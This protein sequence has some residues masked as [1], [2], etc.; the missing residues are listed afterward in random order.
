MSKYAPFAE[1][2]GGLSADAARL[3]FAEIEQIIGASLPESAHRHAAWWANSRTDDSHVWAH[4]WLR[5]GWEKSALNLTERWVEFRRLRFYAIDSAE[6]IEGYE[7]DVKLLARSRNRELAERCRQRDNFS[8]QACHFRF[9]I[10]GRFV[11]DVHHKDPLSV[12]GETITNLDD[13]VCLCPTCHRIAHLRST[14]Y[15]VDEIGALR[16]NL[17]HGA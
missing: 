15:T 2:L 10:D 8:C 7:R 16:G 6:A 9:S 17:V 4:L 14:P 11:I 13:L 1:H 3:S 12:T 5:A